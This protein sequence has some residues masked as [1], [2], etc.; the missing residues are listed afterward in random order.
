MKRNEGEVNKNAYGVAGQYALP[1]IA[2][3][4]WK[5]LP[6]LVL[7]LSLQAAYVGLGTKSLVTITKELR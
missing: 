5:G 4:V 7:P 6:Q 2:G 1:L 3:T